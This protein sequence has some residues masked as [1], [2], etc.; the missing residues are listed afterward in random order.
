MSNGRARG[1]L[2]VVIAALLCLNGVGGGQQPRASAHPAPILSTQGP[3]R[4]TSRSDVIRVVALGDSVTAGSNC[5]C[6]DFVDRYSDIVRARTRR[7]VAATNL[8]R[9]GQTSTGLL[10]DLRRDGAMARR[11]AGAD[12]VLVTIGANDFYPELHRWQDDGC[13]R[14]C[15]TPRTRGVEDRV[16]R[17]VTQVNRLRENRSALVLVT[18]YRNVFQDGEVAVRRFGPEFLSWSDGLTRAANRGICR[19]ARSAGARCTNLYEPFKAADGGGDPTRLLADDG[20]HPNAAGHRVI[21][22]ALAAT[23]VPLP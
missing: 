11:V 20:D 17:V 12:V 22:R 9:P 14:T 15:W 10:R 13:D 3:A 8:G 4:S 18:D 21:A 7:A 23:G 2:V 6:R 16:E 19:G 1:F 5:D